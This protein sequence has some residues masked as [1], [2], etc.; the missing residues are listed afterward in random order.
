ML[1]GADP[2]PD[3][4]YDTLVAALRAGD[5]AVSS[6]AADRLLRTY[7]RTGQ[8]PARPVVGIVFQGGTEDWRRYQPL[9]QRI[10]AINDILAARE[11]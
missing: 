11:A 1:Y 3:E 2:T 5:L 10:A 7:W 6:S 8:K 4:A 9:V